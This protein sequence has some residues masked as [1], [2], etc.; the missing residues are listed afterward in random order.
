MITLELD[1]ELKYHKP[2]KG[3][4]VIHVDRV[5]PPYVEV[6]FD[7]NKFPW[8]FRDNTFDKVLARD[9]LEHLRGTMS[10]I[11]G[12]YGICRANAKVY[13]RVPYWS[14]YKSFGDPTHV[15]TFDEHSFNYFGENEYP[16][17][18]N[19]RFEVIS[20]EKEYGYHAK[21]YL[22][23]F[24]K[25]LKIAEE[26]LLNIVDEINFELVVIK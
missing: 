11:E 22:R 7:L 16:F 4:E 20:V 15:Q 17:Y 10:V 5:K 8:P 6:V 2:E 21:K 9:V 12:I 13:I 14:C 23:H 3:E 25:L 19:A 1:S 26:T 24:P 18:T